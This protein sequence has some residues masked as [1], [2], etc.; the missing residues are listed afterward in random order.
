[1]VNVGTVNIS[2]MDG[3]GKFVSPKIRVAVPHGYDSKQLRR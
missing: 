2:Y 3:M 1:M